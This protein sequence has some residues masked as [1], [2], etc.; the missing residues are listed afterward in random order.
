MKTITNKA[1]RI[2][3]PS[4]EQCASREALGKDASRELREMRPD[5]VR[6]LGG[7]GI[8]MAIHDFFHRDDGSMKM[9]VV[10]GVRLVVFVV[11]WECFAVLF[12]DAETG[13]AALHVDLLISLQPLSQSRGA[14]RRLG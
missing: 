4:K 5:T 10:V 12:L 6:R 2:L 9:L 1:S 14:L 13:E 11:A 3:I 8:S 7:G